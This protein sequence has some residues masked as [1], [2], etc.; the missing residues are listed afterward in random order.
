[1]LAGW[2]RSNLNSADQ[3]LTYEGILLHL[4]PSVEPR[5]QLLE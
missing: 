4:R 1:M 2:G 5:H 3:Q